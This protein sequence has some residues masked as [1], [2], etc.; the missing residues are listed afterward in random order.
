[1]NVQQIRDKLTR[2]VNRDGGQSEFARSIGTSPGY[3]NDVLSGRRDPGD[4]I[5]NALGLERV[6]VYQRKRKA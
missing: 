1:M 5:L 3:V 2:R 6:T 4:K